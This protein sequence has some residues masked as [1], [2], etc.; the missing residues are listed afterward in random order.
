[1]SQFSYEEYEKQQAARRANAANSNGGKLN[2]TQFINSFLK[3]DGDTVVVRFPYES[4]RDIMFEATHNV[5]FPGD[6]WDKRVR[7]V[8][9]G[10]PL[11]AN[12]VKQDVRF[13]VKALIYKIDDNTGKMQILPAIWDRA[14]AFADRDI[15]GK[16]QQCAEDGIGPLSNNLVKIRKTGSGLETRYSLDII[17]ASNKM[18]NSETCPP[19]FELLDNVDPL[20]ILTRTYEQ[21]ENALNGGTAESSTPVEKVE[22][23]EEVVSEPKFTSP[24]QTQPIQTPAVEHKAEP[25]SEA[26]VRRPVRF[27]F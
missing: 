9:E 21:Y 20:R 26:E 16:M 6:K 4:M 11:C 17:A 1:M 2:N 22:V 13:F 5:R 8:G 18:Y 25:A 24:V 19:K 23:K 7:C 12:G 3:N 27:S 15:K 10:C 14:A